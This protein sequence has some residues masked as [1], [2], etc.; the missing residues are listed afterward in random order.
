MNRLTIRS[1]SSISR[2]VSASRRPAIAVI[3]QR[4]NARLYGS[5]TTSSPKSSEG[6][7]AESGG[8][9][10][11]DAVKTGS[12]PTAGVLPDSLADGDARGRTG[13]GKPLESSHHAPPQPKIDNGSVPGSRPNLTS[14]QQAE[15]DA[16]NKEFE[17][18]HG[19]ADS[20]G[21]DKSLP[22]LTPRLTHT[23]DHTVAELQ[24]TKMTADLHLPH[25][26]AGAY[27]TLTAQCHC[28]SVHFTVHVPT[29]ALPL[30][31]HLCHCS[32]CRQT[33][34]TFCSF[35][36][37]LPRDVEPVFISPSSIES[38]LTGYIHSPQ[39]ASERFFCTTCGCHIGD[40]DLRP[41]W[42]DPSAGK[43]EWRIATS[44]FSPQDEDTFQIRSH[45]FTTPS[46]E[47]NLATW[48]PS[49]NSR[50]I[51][52]WNP[53]PNDPKFPLATAQLLKPD[54]KDNLLLAECH[55]SGVRFTIP[56]PSPEE[57]SDPFL[58]RFLRP[59]A[60][61]SPSDAPQPAQRVRKPSSA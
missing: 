61:P 58:S 2:F 42:A 7:S 41:D 15:V 3:S 11:K 12:S 45:V 28:K 39:A 56:H 30:P 25:Q 35:H 22:N 34:G 54:I 18:K 1:I 37:P 38:S 40:R 4:A 50:A 23:T 44:I 14:E 59:S 53:A 32:I 51:H 8:S 47:P 19:R 31:V 5:R 43:P 27:K 52:V 10:S 24:W 17:K 55:C 48:L 46:I 57:A 29:S 60:I 26:Q 20:A 49:I 21:D 9:R 33:H 36:A 6:P 13:G 16:H